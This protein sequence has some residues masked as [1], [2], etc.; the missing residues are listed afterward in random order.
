MVDEL[1]RRLRPEVPGNPAS[2]AEAAAALEAL[3]VPELL[4]SLATAR[5]ILRFGD[6]FH[7]IARFFVDGSPEQRYLLDLAREDP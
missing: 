3:G 2:R 7:P 6:S 4:R 1:A 5:A